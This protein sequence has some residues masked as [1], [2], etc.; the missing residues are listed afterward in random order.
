LSTVP[1]Y[2]RNSPMNVKSLTW[3]F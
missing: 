3:A 1:L 2:K